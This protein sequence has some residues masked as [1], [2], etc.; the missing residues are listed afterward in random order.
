MYGATPIRTPSLWRQK[1]SPQTRQQRETSFPID[2][3]ETLPKVS[4]GNNFSCFSIFLVTIKLFSHIYD[5][6]HTGRALCYL[7][8]TCAFLSPE[9]LGQ[10]TYNTNNAD[11][12]S[13]SCMIQLWCQKIGYIIYYVCKIS[14]ILK[15]N[16]C[17][18][19]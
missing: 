3:D 8:N 10:F 4:S 11:L 17:K 7:W 16:Q 9:L 12:L 19:V 5:I 2:P 13:C 6:K 14:N 15:I 18:G 1:T